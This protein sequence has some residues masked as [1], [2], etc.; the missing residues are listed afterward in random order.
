MSDIPENA[1]N[2]VREVQSQADE[3]Q[4]TFNRRQTHVQEKASA[5]IRGEFS[6]QSPR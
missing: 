6:E 5:E 3:G 4:E 1:S 2:R